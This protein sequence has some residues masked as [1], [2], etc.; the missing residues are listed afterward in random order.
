MSIFSYIMRFRAAILIF[1]LISCLLFPALGHAQEDDPSVREKKT[2][3]GF[4][5]DLKSLIN[6]SKEKIEE[7]NVKIEE[8]EK[9]KRNQQR[10][11]KAR[12]YYEKGKKLYDEGKF[13]KAAE[14]F[15]RAIKI[16]EHP[17]MKGYVRQSSAKTK[18]EREA[19]TDAE[20]RRLKQLEIERGFNAKEVEK[21][22]AKAVA[23]FKREKF[24]EARD[25]FQAVD[26]MFPDH[27]ATRSYLMLINQRIQEEQDSLITK[28]LKSES[29][30]S[31]KEKAV[32]KGDLERKAKMRRDQL[33]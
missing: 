19:L 4:L 24:L 13:D 20:K 10:E 11:E 30:A 32:W 12:E 22:Y 23:L 1:S 18:K 7:A 27:K 28:Q 2:K 8:Q 21:T 6:R 9:Y 3:D 17:E 5:I 15:E 14:F 16:T 29:D 33:E 31:R 26:K 25:N